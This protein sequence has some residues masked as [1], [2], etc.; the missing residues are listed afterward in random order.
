MPLPEGVEKKPAEA[1]SEQ[2]TKASASIVESLTEDQV[3]AE[4]KKN[5][6]ESMKVTAKTFTPAGLT[7]SV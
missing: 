6:F 7:G 5:P 1:A 4:A 3:K 2:K